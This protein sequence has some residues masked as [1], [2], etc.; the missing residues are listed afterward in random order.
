MLYIYTELYTAKPI[1]F[2]Q[3]CMQTDWTITFL[4]F[5]YIFFCECLCSDIYTYMRLEFLFF[6]NINKVTC[7]SRLAGQNDPNGTRID[8]EHI[9]LQFENIIKLGQLHNSSM[10]CPG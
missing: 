5:K 3:I 8:F 1:L 10:N 9:T 6:K 4:L 7:L 2:M